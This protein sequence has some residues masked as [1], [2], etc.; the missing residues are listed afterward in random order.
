MMLARISQ[1]L[2]MVAAAFVL[3]VA[4]GAC[5]ASDGRAP[6][7]TGSATATCVAVG[8]DLRC[9]DVSTMALAPVLRIV[10]GDTLHVEFE[11]RD[12][13]VRLYGIDAPEVGTPCATD[14]TARLRELAGAAVR[15]RPDARDRDRYGRLLRYVYTRDGESV[16]ATL[17]REGLARAWRGDGLLEPPIVALEMDARNT[18]RGCLWKTAG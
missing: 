13:S 10:D 15:L 4:V 16:D 14:A 8:D 9:A 3:L 5:H 6:A 18:R 2:G 12:E 7:E 1:R 17:V 11:G